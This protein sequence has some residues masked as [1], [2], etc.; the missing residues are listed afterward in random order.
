M[1]KTFP[2]HLPGKADPRVLDAIKG[3]VR[4]YV[5]RERRKPV[6][7]G[8]DFW[9]F[10]CRIGVNPDAAETKP[11]AEIGKAIDDIAASGAESVYVEV[12][13]KPGVRPPRTPR[14]FLS[15]AVSP[16]NNPGNT[17]PN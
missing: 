12:L 13:A 15:G 10:D 6:R 14:I 9:D 2:L 5:K 17:E 4:K 16:E 11:L 3:D 1:K 8:V 7:E